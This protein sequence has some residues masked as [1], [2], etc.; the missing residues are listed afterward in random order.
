MTVH[1]PNAVAEPPGGNVPPVD[2]PTASLFIDDR[3]LRRRI[4]PK[5]GWDKFRAAVRRAEQTRSIG[6]RDFPR[7]SALWGGRY[8]PAVVAYLDDQNGVGEY[9]VGRTEDGPEDFHATAGQASGL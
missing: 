5:L 7:V 9:D 4:N 3:E 1:T 6:G 8:W 2:Q